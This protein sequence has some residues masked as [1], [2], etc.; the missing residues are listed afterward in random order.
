MVCVA[1]EWHKSNTCFRASPSKRHTSYGVPL[2]SR[3]R[4]S[5]VHFILFTSYGWQDHHP[6]CLLQDDQWIAWKQPT[7]SR[8]SCISRVGSPD[9]RSQ[10]RR[11]HHNKRFARAQGCCD[12]ELRV[13]RIQTIH[14]AHTPL[15]FNLAYSSIGQ[16]RI[17]LY[18]SLQHTPLLSTPAH[19]SAVHNPDRLLWQLFG[20]HQDVHPKPFWSRCK[21][22]VGNHV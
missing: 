7:H 5:I 21:F 15:L 12:R 22:V 6:N 13:T 8:F 9:E 3:K 17:L 2:R 4:S 10:E 1:A 14:S 20:L 18:C 19:S 11:I 16:F